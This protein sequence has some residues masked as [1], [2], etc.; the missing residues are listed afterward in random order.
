MNPKTEDK[1]ERA[2]EIAKVIYD[3]LVEIEGK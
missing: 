2:K 1:I 3:N